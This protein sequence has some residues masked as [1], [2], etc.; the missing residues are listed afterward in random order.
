M[1]KVRVRARVK[2]R[3]SVRVRFMAAKPKK[4]KCRIIRGS[5]NLIATF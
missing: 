3:V 5:R 1:V 4:P 2:V